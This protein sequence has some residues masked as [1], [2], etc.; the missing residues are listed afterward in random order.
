MA[1]ITLTGSVA[2]TLF[3]DAAKR[4]MNE[5]GAISQTEKLWSRWANVAE[6]FGDHEITI[7]LDTVHRMLVAG[8]PQT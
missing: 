4:K 7:D 6:Q 1:T 2:A 8:A 5:G 3:R